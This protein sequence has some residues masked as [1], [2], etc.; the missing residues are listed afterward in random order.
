MKNFPDL[1]L[2]T[3]SLLKHITFLHDKDL[4]EIYLNF[5]TALR[6][7]LTVPVTVAQAERSFS[8]LKLIKTYLRSTMSQEWL[9]GLAVISIN[10]SIG[11]QISYD[12]II[13]DFPSRK[14]SFSLCFLFL[15]Q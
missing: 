4:S 15:V 13:D 7:A 6:I 5:W 1:P 12:D 3:T 10:H 8:K 9:T 14:A 11:E 2:K